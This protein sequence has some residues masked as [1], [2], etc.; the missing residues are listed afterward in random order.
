MMLSYNPSTLS[1]AVFFLCCLYLGGNSHR[2]VSALCDTS[3]T[4]LTVAYG[5]NIPQTCITVPL[6]DD[7]DEGRERCFYTYVPKSCNETKKA[8]LVV[9]V[10]G[11]GSCPLWSAGY[12][13]W[14]QKAEEEC[15]VVMWPNGNEHPLMPRCFNTP[16][17]L[18]S[19]DMETESGDNNDVTAMPCCCLDDT[20]FNPPEKAIDPLFLKMAIDTVID[21]RSEEVVSIDT[22]RIYMAGHSNGCMMSLAMAALY[23]D[24]IAAVCCHA[25][26][27][28]TPF[29]EDYTP[30][31]IW[32][33]HGME[34]R[35]IKY[36]GE[37]QDTV[38][39]KFGVWSMDQTIDYLAKEN[40]CDTE[41]TESDLTDDEDNVIGKV[42]QKTGCKA[43]VELVALFESGHFPYEIPTLFQGMLAGS[44]E[45]ATTIDTT[46]MAWD[47]C[48]AY[49]KEDAVVEEDNG[50]DAE[51]SSTRS[52]Y[53]GKLLLGVLSSVSVLSSSM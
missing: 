35:V 43:D 1:S 19:D 37:S 48:S 10:H 15:F 52:S 32:M 50:D 44:G 45:V 17:F 22:N 6:G 42:V 47:F 14:M 29:D 7:D 20:T 53:S 8:P 27:V 46:A 21:E 24:T 5:K 3:A 49:S 2:L 13:G 26:A 36:E 12:T 34:D 33:V 30:V 4:A 11:M 18:T 9:D 16:G 40:G 38:F 51:S 25:G 23:S 28:L 31:P 41:A 39:G